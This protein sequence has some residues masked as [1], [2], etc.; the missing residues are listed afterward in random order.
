MSKE[1]ANSKIGTLYKMRMLTREA[2]EI[3]ISPVLHELLREV[4]E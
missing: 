1:E 4:E 2:Q 3:R